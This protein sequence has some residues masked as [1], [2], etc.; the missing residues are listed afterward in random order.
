LHDKKTNLNDVDVIYYCQTDTQGQ[1]AQNAICQLQEKLS[2]VYWQVKN[3]ALMHIKRQ[4][5]QYT[6]NA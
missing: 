3:Q 6:S 1:L 4:N 5:S 2:K